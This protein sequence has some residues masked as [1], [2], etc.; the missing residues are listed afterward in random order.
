[1][2]APGLGVLNIPLLENVSADETTSEA[3]Y[4]LGYKELAVYVTGTGTTSSGVITI[5]TAYYQPN[6]AASA[7]YAG[8]WSSIA[9]VNASDVTGGAQKHV[10]ITD[11]AYA[12]VRTRVSTAIGGGGTISTALVGV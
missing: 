4:C 5:E 2:A 7:P 10:P 6:V 8:T 11:S 9:T 3:V 1:M 12:W